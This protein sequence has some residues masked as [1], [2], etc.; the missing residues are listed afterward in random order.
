MTFFRTKQ[1]FGKAI[2]ICGIAAE[3]KSKRKTKKWTLSLW[4]HFLA[5]KR[6]RSMTGIYFN[7]GD[8]GMILNCFLGTSAL[9]VMRSRYRSGDLAIF[10]S[11]AG[12]MV[13]QDTPVRGSRTSWGSLVSGNDYPFL[14]AMLQSRKFGEFWKVRMSRR[15]AVE[16]SLLVCWI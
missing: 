4:N 5:L 15:W 12:S 6:L 2:L 8:T 3:K 13:L 1:I 16:G 14:W 11:S 9:S 10:G 7:G